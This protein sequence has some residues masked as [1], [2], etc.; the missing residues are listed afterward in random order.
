MSD[1]DKKKEKEYFENIWSKV[2]I[3]KRLNYFEKLEEEVEE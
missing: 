1:N 3:K 2:P